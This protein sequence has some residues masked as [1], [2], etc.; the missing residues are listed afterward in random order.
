MKAKFISPQDQEWGNFLKQ[1]E[2]DFYH[3]PEYVEFVAQFEEGIPLAFFVEDKEP[4]LLAP[5]LI[6]ELPENLDV[7]DDWYDATSPYGYGAPILWPGGSANTLR[8]CLHLFREVANERGIVTAFFRLNPLLDLPL[9]ALSEYG[10]LF[11]H[12]QTVPIDL[13]ASDEEIQSQIRSNHKRNIR[14]LNREGF[15]ADMDRWE[16][17]DDFIEIYE[18]T[19]HRLSASEFYL[20]PVRYF[21]G[22]RTAL[23]TSLHL[24]TV[25]SPE[26]EVAAAGLFTS[27]CGIVQY[28][29]G[30]T[31]SKY[32]SFAPAKL[33]FD[34]VCRWAKEEGNRVFHL[35]GGVGGQDDSLF[36]FKAGFSKLRNDFFTYRMIVDE[37]KYRL[38]NDQWERQCGEQRSDLEF[39]PPYRIPCP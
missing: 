12:G 8:S 9:D 34:H 7:S 14:K 20:F 27:V 22:L 5:L 39:F 13:S 24:C 2:H 4:I 28:H 25:L 1:S 10:D 11:H 16:Y 32:L 17:F 33:M 35:G 29:L 31:N 36:Q 6:R 18:A 23:G 26:G 37:E 30:G 21:Y 15:Q 3:L 38:L 19:M